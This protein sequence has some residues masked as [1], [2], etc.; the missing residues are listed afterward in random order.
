MPDLKTVVTGTVKL[1]NVEGGRSE[2]TA[3]TMAALNLL[4]IFGV[5]SIAPDTSGFFSITPDQLAAANVS[6]GTIFVF[7]F[8][9]KIK[10]A[11]GK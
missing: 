8:G 1:K 9:S 7:F 6:L 2:L 11:G 10:T 4:V 3:V 5:I